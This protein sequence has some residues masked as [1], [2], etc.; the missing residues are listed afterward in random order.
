M[1]IHLGC[2][3]DNKVQDQE[4][5]WY[6][7]M[8][9]PANERRAPHESEFWGRKR[10]ALCNQ[11]QTHSQLTVRAAS[12]IHKSPKMAIFESVGSVR[13]DEAVVGRESQCVEV[14][15]GHLVS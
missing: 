5:A 2:A 15:R 1:T 10:L 9:S 8:S 7:T 4:A 6:G 12:L 13:D 14:S 3:K 11:K